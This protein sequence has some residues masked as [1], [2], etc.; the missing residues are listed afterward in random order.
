MDNG[1]NMVAAFKMSEYTSGKSENEMSDDEEDSDEANDIEEE[2]KKLMM[3]LRRR[4]RLRSEINQCEELEDEHCA[5]FSHYKQ[6]SCGIHIL[7]LVV[8]LFK[9][10]PYFCKTLKTAKKIVAKVN[11]ST[12]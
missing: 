1:S 10:S 11:K 2:E 8:K 4:E 9:G 5:N 3:I 12:W 7:Q 6:I